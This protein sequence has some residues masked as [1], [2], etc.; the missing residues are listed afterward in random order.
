[1]LVWSCFAL[2]FLLHKSFTDSPIGDD[3]IHPYTDTPFVIPP[4][5]LKSSQ[6]IEENPNL[7]M[8]FNLSHIFVRYSFVSF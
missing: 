7:C 5:A 4:G 3:P 1:M 6:P 8:A 2:A